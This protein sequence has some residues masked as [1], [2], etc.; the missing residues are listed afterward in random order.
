MTTRTIVSLFFLVA[1]FSTSY[2][3][4]SAETPAKI[5]LEEIKEIQSQVDEMQREQFEKLWFPRVLDTQRGG[6]HQTW[7]RRWEAESD[8]DTA[9]VVQA[10]YTWSAAAMA[11]YAPELADK[12]KHYTAHGIRF[13]DEIMRDKE[14]GGFHWRLDPQGKL[15]DKLGDEKHAY[16]IAFAIYAACKAYEVTHDPRALAVARDGFDWIEKHGYDSKYGGYY[17]AFTRDGTPITTWDPNLPLWKRQDRLGVY[18]GFKTMNTHIHLLEAFAELAK[19]DQRPLVA[20]RHEEIHKIVRDKIAVAPG[21]LNLYFTRDWRATAAHDSFGHDIETAYLLTESAE[22][23]DSAQQELTW[24]VAKQLVDHALDWGWDEKNGGFFDKGDAIASAAYDTD[25]VWWIQAEGLN[26][27]A[28]MHDKYGHQTDRYWI[29]LKKQWSF[30]RNYSVDAEYGDWYWE[31]TA[32]GKQ[33]GDGQKANAWK[34]CYHTGRSL[35]NVSR[36]LKKLAAK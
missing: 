16:G 4:L 17:E 15:S 35:M 33:L 32:D 13:L 9:I 30:I 5:S 31:V 27:L 23:L 6:F 11:E 2:S 21:C 22:Q 10:R 36:I 29:A 1:V 19:I 26:A 14:H 3:H 12:Y 34:A 20:Q 25:K 8:N 18:Y 7:N 28:Y 24:N